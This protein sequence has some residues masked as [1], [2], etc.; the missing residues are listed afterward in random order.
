MRSMQEYVGLYA[1]VLLS[2]GEK[3]SVK[4]DREMSEHFRHYSSAVR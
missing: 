4:L 2:K 3:I 1:C